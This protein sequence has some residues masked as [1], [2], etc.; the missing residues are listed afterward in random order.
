MGVPAWK[1][2]KWRLTMDRL[3]RLDKD[4]FVA[5]MQELARRKFEEVAD[6]VND[7]SDGNVISGS[8]MR[9]R[10]IMGELRCEAF[11]L[12]L[13]MRIDSTE[14]SFFPSEGPVGPGEAEQ[15]PQPPQHAERERACESEPH[16][17]VRPAG[18]Q[19]QSG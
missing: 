19:R 14:S 2:G 3:L 5:R 1:P 12:A 15:G 7:A 4:A 11:E 16:S 18:G 6:A 8:E 9:V 17:L 13:Q 10:D